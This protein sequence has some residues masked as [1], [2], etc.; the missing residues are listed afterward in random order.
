MKNRRRPALRGRELTVRGTARIDLDREA[1]TGVPEIILAEGKSPEDVVR[2]A[3]ALWGR[4][5][6]SVISR[7]DATHRRAL[8]R[9]H[10]AGLP[11]TFAARGRVARVGPPARAGPPTDIVA[12]LTAGTADRPIAEE[13][14]AVLDALGV[15]T[16][17]ADDV[18]VAGLHRLLRALERLRPADPAVYVVCAGREGALPTVVAGLVPAPVLGVPTSSGYGRGG[19]GEAA[20][21]AMLQSCAPIAV[22][23]IDGG[24]PAAL[25]AAQ[26]VR[27]AHRRRNVAPG[28][29]IRRVGKVRGSRG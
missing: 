4:Q 27:A 12:V 24:V 16:R 8:S 20:L 2:I 23:N 14:V 11:V 3:T 15:R 26:I 18:G 22:V 19:R 25:V 7:L 1:R 29:R 17:V 5:H 28:P 10:R 21:S 6:G 13:I 9:A